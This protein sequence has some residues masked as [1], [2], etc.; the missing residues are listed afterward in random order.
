MKNIVF[1]ILLS[2]SF[3]LNAQEKK[4]GEF[5]E[6]YK[7]FY[8]ITDPNEAISLDTI[9]L[10]PAPKFKTSYDRRYYLWMKKKTYNAY[11][12]AVLAKEKINM[13][14]DTINLIKSSRKRKRF[15]KEK[16]QFFEDEFAKKIK[17]LTR[18]EGR[19]LI[20]LI[21]RLTGYTVNDHVKN[22]RGKFKAFIYR[23]SASLFKIKLNLEYHPESVMEDYMIESILQ[24]AFN[25]GELESHPSVLKT[26]S[27][28]FPAKVIEIEKKK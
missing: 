7:D 19:V 12:Y 22:K 25:E 23:F 24:H 20:K 6:K 4:K 15:I 28:V 13:L 3:L 16:Q 2:C 27:M 14:N 26:A 8:L 18:T 1:I 5:E 10:F 21:H 9:V 11:P 17:K